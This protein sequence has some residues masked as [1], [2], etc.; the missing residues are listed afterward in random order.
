[1]GVQFERGD[2][3]FFRH[4]ANGEETQSGGI[5]ISLEDGL[6]T[7][8]LPQGVEVWNMRSALFGS[9]WRVEHTPR[10][11]D[12]DEALDFAEMRLDELR[13]RPLVAVDPADADP[14][15]HREHSHEHGLP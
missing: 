9:A 5:V 8:A 3:V 1:V 12:E 4:L 6:L 15:V 14:F 7:I 2:L 10:P 13:R 11:M